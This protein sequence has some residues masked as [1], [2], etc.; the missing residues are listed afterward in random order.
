VYCVPGTCVTF[1]LIE[2]IR[3]WPQAGAGCEFEALVS[4]LAGRANAPLSGDE[5]QG[6]ID[7]LAARGLA[8]WTG[9]TLRLTEPDR[10]ELQ[11]YAPLLKR[12]D[13]P[14]ILREL[15]VDSTRYV[16]QDTSTG[17]QQGSG[18]LSKPDFT[19]ASIRPEKFERALEVTTIEVKNRAGATTTAVY[20]IRA[21]SRVS[22]FPYLAC[23]RM[24]LDTAKKEAVEATCRKEGIGLIVFDIDEDGDGGFRINKLKI[25]MRSKRFY[26][27]RKD[28]NKYLSRRLTEANQAK[29]LSF[30]EGA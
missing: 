13:M 18:L 27:E 14:N 5:V 7:F 11:L 23:P 6:A 8:K 16:L 25:E 28:S 2:E 26:P 21:H 30:V 17:G 12:L 3:A 19:L 9:Q 10:P 15:D 29:L 20:N 1:N 4:Y 22:H 24:R